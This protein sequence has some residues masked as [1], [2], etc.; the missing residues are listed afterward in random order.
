MRPLME[1]V[2]VLQETVAADP[3]P[4]PV[5][6]DGLSAREVEVLGLIAQGKSNR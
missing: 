3:Q 5:Y 1:Q 4:S 2:A 6:P